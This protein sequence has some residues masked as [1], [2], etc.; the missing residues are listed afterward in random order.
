MNIIYI[1]YYMS[2]YNILHEIWLNNTWYLTYCKCVCILYCIVLYC[3]IWWNIKNHMVLYIMIIYNIARS[4]HIILIKSHIKVHYHK[5]YHIPYFIIIYCI[6]IQ[7]IIYDI[8]YAYYLS[9]CN[10]CIIWYCIISN[11][12]VLLFIVQ[13]LKRSPFPFLRLLT[14]RSACALLVFIVHSFAF[15]IH[16]VLVFTVRKVLSPK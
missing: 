3:I 11:N 2:C 6:T 1:T 4:L 16:R 14:V 5:L 12:V 13:S 10:Y 15:C 9:Y 7:D 8:I